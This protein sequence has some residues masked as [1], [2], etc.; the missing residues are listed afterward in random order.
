MTSECR[1]NLIIR[2]NEQLIKK[3]LNVIQDS[4]GCVDFTVLLPPPKN[5]DSGWYI[6]TWGTEKNVNKSE[7]LFIERV[8]GSCSI[9]FITV[10]SPPDRWLN[11]VAALFP[12]LVFTIAYTNV[13]TL[14][15]ERPQSDNENYY[16]ILLITLNIYTDQTWDPVLNETNNWN[17]NDKY[18]QF[19]YDYFTYI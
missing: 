14:Y 8:I 2:G 6:D 3:A 9:E 18:R 16:G 7:S 12:D 17:G 15:N 1:N 4:T 10:N 19:L 5:A 11:A 13:N